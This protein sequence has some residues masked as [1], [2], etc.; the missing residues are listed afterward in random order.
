LDGIHQFQGLFRKGP[1]EFGRPI[2]F[3][4]HFLYHRRE[5]GDRL[6]IRIPGLIFEIRRDVIFRHE[7]RR[8]GDVI[9]MARRG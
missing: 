3:I 7:A 2:P 8:A 9:G 4:A 5:S 6:D 1:T